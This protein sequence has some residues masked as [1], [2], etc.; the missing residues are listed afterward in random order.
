MPWI[1]ISRNL[2]GAVESFSRMTAGA[3]RAFP[4]DAAIRYYKDVVAKL[5]PKATQD[6]VCIMVPGVGHCTPDEARKGTWQH[7]GRWE[8]LMLGFEIENATGS[9]VAQSFSFRDEGGCGT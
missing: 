5:G 7:G 4:S 6:S 8:L 9:V 2:S 3:I 1:R